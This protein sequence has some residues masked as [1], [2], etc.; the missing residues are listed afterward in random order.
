MQIAFR[1][2]LGPGF[3]AETKPL[4]ANDTVLTNPIR[5]VPKLP[6]EL[7]PLRLEEDVLLRPA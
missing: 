3:P 1:L 6:S 5:P 2:G 7:Y 4:P